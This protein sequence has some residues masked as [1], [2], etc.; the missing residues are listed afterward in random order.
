MIMGRRME[1]RSTSGYSQVVGRFSA[2]FLSLSLFKFTLAILESN[3][4]YLSIYS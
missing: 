4:E 1:Y 2:Y 3:F